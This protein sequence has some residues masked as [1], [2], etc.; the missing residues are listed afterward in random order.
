MTEVARF[1]SGSCRSLE[2]RERLFSSL[3][4]L[5]PGAISDVNPSHRDVTDAGFR[6]SIGRALPTSGESGSECLGREGIFLLQV[7]G[8]DKLATAPAF[9]FSLRDG[10][11]PRRS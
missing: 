2:F 11:Q 3:A 4:M 9:C 8:M 6:L 10:K 5:G 7:R 1:S